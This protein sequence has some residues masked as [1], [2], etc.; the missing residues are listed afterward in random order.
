ML[1][2]V[3]Y[4]T[5]SERYFEILK[6]YPE[7]IVLG[8]GKKWN[9]F[10]DKVNATV[11]FCKS[12]KDD[13]I[14]LFVD[15]FDSVI[16]ESTDTILQKYKSLNTTLVFSKGGKSP[17]VIGK[18][19]QDKLF[20][21][22]NDIRLNSGL[23]IGT[24]LSIINFWIDFNI[25]DD[26][27][28]YATEKCN[29]Y[30]Y[31]TIDVNNVLFYNYSTV[32]KINITNHRIIINDNSNITS[33]ISA[34]NNNNMNDILTQ[35]GYVDLPTIKYNNYYRILSY[36]KYFISE[37]ILFLLLIGV[38][39]CFKN[40]FIYIIIFLSVLCV[41]LEY[42]LYV[43]YLDISIISKIILIILDFIHL[44]IILIVIWFLLNLDCNI[45]KLLLLN[46]IMIFIITFFMYFK[47]CIISLISEYLE[48]TKSKPWKSFD[49]LFYLFNTDKLYY[50]LYNENYKLEYLT[51]RWL[52]G[53]KLFYT[54]ACILNI[55]CLWK[56]YTKQKCII[57]KKIF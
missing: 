16:I 24:V 30:D 18:Y 10:Y 6:N 9:G 45:I 28:R 26:D 34:P 25:N 17:N 39:F 46:T 47:R 7:I 54:L 31:I 44:W 20:G 27:Q 42:Q 41:F 23:Y 40:K 11:E 55:Y 38:Y 36:F 21:T 5:H 1:Y 2:I 19:I 35:L 57:N 12:K 15:G 56:I 13:D 29:K 22:C 51:N 53:N 49:R 52:N 48:N 32:D 14:V 3:T 43:K 37:I 33:I 4:A 50:K 8:W